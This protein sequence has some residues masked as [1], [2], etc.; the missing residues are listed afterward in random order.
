MPVFVLEM[1]DHL[2]GGHDLVAQNLSNWIQFVLATPVVLWAGWPFFE[3][4]WQSLETRNLNMFTLIAIGT[5][6]GLV[7]TASSRRSRPACS[8]PISAVTT[9]RSRSISR[10]PPSSP[11]WF[12]SARCWSCAR[13][14]QTIGRDQALLDLAPKTARRVTETAAAKMCRSIGVVVGD[15]LRVRPGEK[16]PVDGVVIEGR[17]L[18]R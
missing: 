9:A 11:F 4:G 13:A 15:R 12:C 18:D 8:P 14:T 6:I 7:S 10:R 3:R 2:A 16:V 17:S 5:G 1:G